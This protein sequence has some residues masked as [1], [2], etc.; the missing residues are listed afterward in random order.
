MMKCTAAGHKNTS[1]LVFSIC[2]MVRTVVLKQGGSGFKY[3]G[4]PGPFCV[5]LILPVPLTRHKAVDLDLVPGRCTMA[6]NCPS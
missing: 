1:C 4:C 6:A 5:E 2:H 3:H